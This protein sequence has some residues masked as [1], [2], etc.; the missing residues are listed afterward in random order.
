MWVSPEEMPKTYYPDCEKVELD[1]KE[2]NGKKVRVCKK[3][4][5]EI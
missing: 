1:V 5:K 3:C 4:G 2:E